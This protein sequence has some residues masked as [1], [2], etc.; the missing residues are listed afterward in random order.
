MLKSSNSNKKE[1]VFLKAKKKSDQECWILMI[2]Y[3]KTVLATMSTFILRFINSET[4]IRLLYWKR[5]VVLPS[6]VL[7][8][9]LNCLLSSL[10]FSL[11][12]S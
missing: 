10:V 9:L 1:V 11:V 7:K 8:S 5:D 12:P 6:L 3:I 4:S 2:F